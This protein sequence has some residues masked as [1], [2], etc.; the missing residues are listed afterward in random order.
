MILDGIREKID[1]CYRDDRERKVFN[2]FL[3]G[4]K[5]QEIGD[6]IDASQ[7]VVSRIERRVSKRINNLVTI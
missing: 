4:L 5:Q 3:D 6:I 7:P 2:L 1:I